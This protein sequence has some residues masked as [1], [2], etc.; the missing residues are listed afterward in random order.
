[1]TDPRELSA[2]ELNKFIARLLD[3]ALSPTPTRAEP[4]GWRIEGVSAEPEHTGLWIALGRMD[5]PE[6]YTEFRFVYAPE[7]QRWSG[8]CP[9]R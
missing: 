9:N 8:A 6:S 5:D 2:P 1:M 7:A 3:D 4:D